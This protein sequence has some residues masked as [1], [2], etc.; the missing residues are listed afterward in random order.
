M[1]KGID[2]LNV[3]RQYASTEYQDRIPILTQDNIASVGDLLVG[4]DWKDTYNEFVG[5]IEKIALTIWVSRAYNNRLKS[6]TKGNLPVG[7]TIEELAIEPAVGTEYDP[8]G[9]YALA[10]V[11]PHTIAYYHN[12]VTQEKY[13]ASISRYQV[14]TAFKSEY[15][16]DRF[17][18]ETVQS[19][20][21]GYEQDDYLKMKEII[22]GEVLNAK[23]IKVAKPT[24][25]ETG[26]AFMKALRNTIQAMTFYNTEYSPVGFP[27]FTPTEN[28]VLLVKYDVISEVSVE[29][30]ASAF[31]R[32]DVDFTTRI[33]TVDNFGSFNDKL[34]GFDV[35]QS[36]YAILLD[37]DG[38]LFYDMDLFMERDHNGDGAFDT[39]TLHV[40]KNY[41]WS[42][43]R[44][45][46]CFCEEKP[47]ELKADKELVVVGK[48]TSVDDKVYK[49][50]AKTTASDM[51]VIIYKDG[52]LVDG[53]ATITLAFEDGTTSTSTYTVTDGVF[54]LSDTSISDDSVKTLDYISVDAIA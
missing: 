42:H 39:L 29:V 1:S 51:S 10:R 14:R 3:M 12:N 40:R 52:E 34:A 16:I 49:N 5:I 7:A 24:D 35:D 38:A 6:L 41:G 53:T 18:E 17:I 20:Y 8:E 33:I 37:T 31:N 22:G 25:A 9:T 47:V 13:R 44:D 50:L 43:I 30:L 2:L 54:N 48:N 21:N 27:T 15:G 26:K 46:A 11:I 36:C 45:I 23:P 19:L 4:A 32:S 28:Q